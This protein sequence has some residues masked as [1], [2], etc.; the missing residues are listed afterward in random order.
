MAVIAALVGVLRSPLLD[1]DAIKVTGAHTV[2]AARIAAASGIS[3]G[4]PVDRRRPGRDQAQRH[5]RAGD[6]LRP[7]LGR[8][9]AHRADRRDRGAPV[10]RPV[11]GWPAADRFGPGLDATGEW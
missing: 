10:G 5:G 9:A 1:V 8:L 2:S 3:T 7:C 4:R 11:D 6:R